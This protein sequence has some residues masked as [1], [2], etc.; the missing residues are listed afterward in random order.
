[1]VVVAPYTT[2]HH[3]VALTNDN[4]QQERSRM[5]GRMDAWTSTSWQGRQ[6]RYDKLAGRCNI[7]TT[8]VTSSLLRKRLIQRAL[9][10]DAILA[11]IIFP[12]RDTRSI[13]SASRVGITSHT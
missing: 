13:C 3:S 9:H 6:L 5:H 12:S 7:A 8:T 2:M 11:A 4:E 1:M 10:T